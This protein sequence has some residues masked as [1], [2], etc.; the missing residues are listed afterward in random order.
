MKQLFFRMNL[1]NYR[2]QKYKRNQSGE[3]EITV[4]GY[5]VHEVTPVSQN[6]ERY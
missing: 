1:Q 6:A 5:E 4:N 3:D 2:N